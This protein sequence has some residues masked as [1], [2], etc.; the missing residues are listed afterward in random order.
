[1]I[2][3]EKLRGLRNRKWYTNM[4]DRNDVTSRENDL[5][6]DAITIPDMPIGK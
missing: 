1:M 5:L 3:V 4:A 2:V 6:L